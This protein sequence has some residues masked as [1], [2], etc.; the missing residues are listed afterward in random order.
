[1]RKIKVHIQLLFVEN[2]TM[3]ILEENGRDYL[4]TN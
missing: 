3:P 2:N 1:M 4:R